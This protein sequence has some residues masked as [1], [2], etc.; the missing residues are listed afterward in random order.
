MKFDKETVQYFS[1]SLRYNISTYIDLY[2]TFISEYQK[3]IE[4]YFK[5]SDED[6]DVE[7]FDFLDSMIEEA[8]KID[9]LIKINK[10]RFNKINHWEF[11][12]FLDDIRNNLNT[13]QNTSKW[14]G[15]NKS[16]NNSR[17]ITIQTNHI[18][19]QN[20]S[21]ESVAKDNSMVDF[22]NDWVNI[23]LQNN[24]LE[25]DYDTNGGN[26]LEISK[27]ISSI[28]KF[29]INSVVD[30]LIG[31]RMYGMDIDKNITFEN[32]DL[33][34]KSFTETIKQSV[35]ILSALRKGDVPEFPSFGIDADLSVG[36]TV[37][38]LIYSS[39]IRQ[40]ITVFSS[41]DTLSDF[42]VT[43]IDYQNSDLIIE[44]SINTFNNKT[45]TN[46]ITI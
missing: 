37:G 20:E 42:N 43:S 9:D 2:S 13:I 38:K 10:K 41:D 14:I 29:S 7:A 15:S 28:K 31:Y 23:S 35:L 25:Q 46:K 6:A 30:S 22:Q 24:I 34:V 11:V 26:N 27:D 16:K 33:K 44:F 18:L 39:I 4:N 17:S 8:T 21:L 12:C 5:F 40:L 1:E 45:L 3:K 32:E 36:N 19:L